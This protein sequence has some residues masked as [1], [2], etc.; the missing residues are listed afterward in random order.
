MVIFASSVAITF[1]EFGWP[2]PR[3]DVR[4]PMEFAE[5]LYTVTDKGTTVIVSDDRS[6]PHETVHPGLLFSIKGWESPP[7][8]LARGGY[9]WKP[10]LAP[11]GPV[12]IV[13]S[14]AAG[15]AFVYRNGVEIGRAPVSVPGAKR[16]GVQVFTALDQRDPNGHREWLATTSIGEGEKLNLSALAAQTSMPAE[17]LQKVREVVEAGATLIISDLGVSPAT[18]SKPGFKILNSSARAMPS[19]R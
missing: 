3:V 5:K 1:S 12:T 10:E 11:T 14:T 15:V 8:V 16:I 18:Q 13:V 2:R 6:G 17:F 4:L 7:S 9:V 19:K